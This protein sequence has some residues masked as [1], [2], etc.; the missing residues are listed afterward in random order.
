L[1]V[2]LIVYFCFKNNMNIKSFF[3]ILAI[4]IVNWTCNQSIGLKERGQLYHFANKSETAK[5]IITDDKEGFFTK[6]NPIDVS[7]QLKDNSLLLDNQYLSKYHNQLVKDALEFTDEEKRTIDSLIKDAY[8]M[9][10]L[11]NVKLAHP[12]TL[13]K[14]DLGH[15]GPGVFY[16]RGTTIFI[17][18][19]VLEPIDKSALQRTLLHEIWHV[20]SEAHPDLQQKLYATIG[21]T[22]NPN[23]VVYPTALKNKM[24]TNPDGAHDQ[25]ALNINGKKIIP[26]LLSK[27]NLF[28]QDMP[29]FF[30]YIQFELYTLNEQGEVEIN[31]DLTPKISNEEYN[32]FFKSI[33]DNTDYIIH[34]DEII[35]DNFIL[36]VK[37]DT[38]LLSSDGK[39]LLIQI[40]KILKEY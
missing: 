3:L 34:P 32:E 37:N 16:T 19:N 7:I 33:K 4:I 17:P 27:H 40:Q 18:K 23:K 14:I 22:P 2:A 29:E 9:I 13:S 21:F 30:N 20:L 1:V 26:I 28:R 6:I 35:A 24:L 25:Y 10:K 38:K 8:R 31:E 39:K 11:L 5:L 12:V 15:Y 36:A